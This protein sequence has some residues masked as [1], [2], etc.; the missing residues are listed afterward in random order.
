GDSKMVVTATTGS[1][2]LGQLKVTSLF[3]TQGLDAAHI[4]VGTNSTPIPV[5]TFTDH[6]AGVYTNL[7]LKADAAKTLLGGYFKVQTDGATPVAS[8]QLVGVAPRVILDQAVD[9]AYGLQSHLT[10]SGT[11][12]VNEAIAVS[13]YINTAGDFTATGR[14]AALQAMIE[15]S[16]TI[17]GDVFVAYLVN[18]GTIQ[19]TDAIAKLYNQSAAETT[20]MLLIDNDNAT[21]ADDPI[22]IDV[23]GRATHGLRLSN[24]TLQQGSANHYLEIGSYA[25]AISLALT[26]SV[27]ASITNLKSTNDTDSSKWVIADYSKI[28]IDDENSQP[29]N[30]VAVYRPKLAIETNIENAWGIQLDVN[31]T[32]TWAVNDLIGVGV[33]LDL[34]SG[35]ITT[36]PGKVAGL[37]VDVYGEGTA[38]VTGNCYAGLF[39]GRGNITGVLD[40]ILQV[41]NQNGAVTSIIGMD[42][43]GACT[44]AFNFGGAAC[45]AWTSGDGAISG[46]T[47]E[48]VKIP[49]KVEGITPTLYILAAEAW[50]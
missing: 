24:I 13:A 23:E 32:G 25:S 48:Y 44:Y 36:T 35:T 9:T 28:T 29:N 39:R 22:M 17:T 14:V 31:C 38:V 46:S 42:V 12:G 7:Q 30:N 8:A 34:G 10:H 49:V 50:V 15:G 4:T 33:F 20:T 18:A 5:A 40:A 11:G 3:G 37:Q 1:A 27:F 19:T 2:T 21:P 16:S 41:E 43:D 6:V 26:D 47:D 45:D